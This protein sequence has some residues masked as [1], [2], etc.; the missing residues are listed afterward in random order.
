MRIFDVFSMI[1]IK[2]RLLKP[3]PGRETVP[4]NINLLCKVLFNNLIFRRSGM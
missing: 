4:R 2:I 1:E 3:F